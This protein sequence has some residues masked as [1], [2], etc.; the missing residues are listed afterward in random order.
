M[1]DWGANLFEGGTGN[2]ISGRFGGKTGLDMF[3]SYCN[4]EA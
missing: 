4:N 2:P 3:V 1:I